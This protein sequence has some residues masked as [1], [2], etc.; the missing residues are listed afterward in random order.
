LL[1]VKM[2]SGD[3]LARLILYGITGPSDAAAYS[4]SVSNTLIGHTTDVISV[5]IVGKRQKG[6]GQ[7]FIRLFRNGVIW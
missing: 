5:N 3:D 7:S 4:I 1:K 2:V 6:G